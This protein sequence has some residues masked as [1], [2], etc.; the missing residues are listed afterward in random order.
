M[1]V[2]G[3]DCRQEMF[4]HLVRLVG[5]RNSRR[6]GGPVIVGTRAMAVVPCRFLV[7]A[8]AERAEAPALPP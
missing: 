2:D 3:P 7:S 1:S 4:G 8:Q 5:S 6:E